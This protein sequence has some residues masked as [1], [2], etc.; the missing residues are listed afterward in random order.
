MSEEEDKKIKH[1]ASIRLFEE[2]YARGCEGNDEKAVRIFKDYEPREAVQRFRGE[3]IAIKN[4]KVTENVINT[5]V[6]N[7]RVNKHGSAKRWAELMLIW[8]AKNY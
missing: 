2:R 4:E 7:K 3:L 1:L 8:L 5:W 6:G